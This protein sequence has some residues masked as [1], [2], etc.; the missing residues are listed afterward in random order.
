VNARSPSANTKS[1]RRRSSLC[2]PISESKESHAARG[3]IREGDLAA[4]PVADM[5][6]DTTSMQTVR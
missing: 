3:H 4:N 1:P 6:H 5:N 2:A